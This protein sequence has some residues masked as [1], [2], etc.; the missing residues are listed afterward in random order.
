MLGGSDVRLARFQII[1]LAIDEHH[2]I[3]V[4]LDRS[5]F[6]Q[7]GEHRA[8]V[9]AIVD[10]ARELRQRHDRDIQLLRQRLQAF[11]HFGDFLHAILGPARRL[12]QL[13]IIDRDQPDILLPLQSART[14]CDLRDRNATGIV[15]VK[16]QIAQ[17]LRGLHEAVPFRVGKT[18]GADFSHIDFRLLGKNAGGKLRGRHLERKKQHRRSA[19]RFDLVR[20]VLRPKPSG[21]KR[22]IG[23][24]RCLAHAGPARDDDEIGRVQPAE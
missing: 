24:E 23:G 16:R 17:H 15:D 20:L 2:H 12:D 21:V 5:G 1:F 22:H 4:L 10:A 9:V 19:R 7:I 6:A 3:R 11:G 8:L 14:R 18:T 13:Q